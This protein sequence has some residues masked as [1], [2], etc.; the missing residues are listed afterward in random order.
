MINRSHAVVVVGGGIGGIFAALALARRGVEVTVC[1]R[2][3]AFE[4]VGAGL[5]LSPNATRLLALEG[6]LEPVRA[7]AVA[8]VAAR[9]RDRGGR[10]IAETRLGPAMERRLGAPYL[11]IHRAD[12]LAALVAAAGAAGVTFRLGAEVAEVDAED[13]AVRLASGEMLASDAV[14]AADGARSR[15]RQTVLGRESPPVF[16]GQIAW[17][18]TAP[19]PAGGGPFAAEVFAG[20]D[21]H[22]VSY[23]LRGGAL[24]NFVGVVE[25]EAWRD[26][27][28]RLAGDVSEMRAAF[29]G[30]GPGGGDL[31]ER[32]ESCFVWGLHDHAPLER[33]RRG[34]LA[35]LG[36]AA[37]PM[38]PFMAQGA[39]MAIEDG[40]VLADLLAR[41]GEVPAALDAYAARRRGRTARVQA[42][43]RGNANLFH[44]RPGFARA[45]VYGA[46]AVGSRIAPAL[47]DRRYDWLYGYAAER[48]TA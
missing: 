25:R 33:W 46:M 15:L 19:A 38:T 26:E 47:A 37:H 13:G 41:G 17:R 1:E 34:R 2:A 16:A 48:D 7:H 28:W 14:I 40:W 12:L 39:G 4:E 11:H 5:Q 29:Q 23:R 3:A 18:A 10:L 43:S 42:L 24:A 6:A 36:D 20:P 8:P 22:L 35:L 30:Y 31:L 21:R 45:A 44:K 27:S 9:L 32:V